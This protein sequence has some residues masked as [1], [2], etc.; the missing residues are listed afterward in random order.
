VRVPILLK[1]PRSAHA[2]ERS[3]KRV[4][5]ID[6]FATVL[7]VAGLPIPAVTAQPLDRTSHEVIIE[8]YQ[9]GLR[10]RRYGKSAE[11][12][13]TAVY[14]GDLK[15]I[16]STSGERRLYNLA[17]DPVEANNLASSDAAAAARMDAMVGAWLDKTPFFDATPEAKLHFTYG[18][19]P[20]VTGD[21]QP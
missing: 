3:S 10:V 2:G 9:N 16:R 17:L 1:Y 14:S 20:V 4:S 6:I 12:D 7:D 15:Y 11:R 8:N 5:T 13:L 18:T 19:G 21:F